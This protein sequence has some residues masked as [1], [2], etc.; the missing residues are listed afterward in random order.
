MTH[1]RTIGWRIARSLGFIPAVAVLIAL[2]L[3]TALV[4]VDVA[5]QASLADRWPRLFGAGPDGARGMLTAIASSMITV[6]GVVFSVTLVALSLASSQYSPRVL[7]TFT[8]D[9]PT[10]LVLA[11]FVGIYVYCLV[12]LRTVRGGDGTEFVPGIA[13]AGGL[14]LAV[15]GIGCLVY[16]IHHLSETVQAAAIVTRIATATLATVERVFPEELSDDAPQAPVEEAEAL[17]GEWLTLPAAQT[18][19]VIQVSIDGLL[20]VSRHNRRVVQMHAGIGDF[21]IKGQPLAAISGRTPIERDQQD[22]VAASYAIDSERTIEQDP[23]YG[24][25]QLVDIARKALSPAMNDASTAVSCVDRLTQILVTLAR[26]KDQPA[27]HREGGELRVI[28]RRPTFESLVHPVYYPLYE[29]A[30]AQHSVTMRLLWSLEQVSASTSDDERRRLL[31]REVQRLWGYVE[32]E[33]ARSPERDIAIARA[34]GLYASLSAH[35][36]EPRGATGS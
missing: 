29:D 4:E 23:A 26:R 36:P 7:R 16:F 3:A 17:S 18:G 12:V 31:A 11:V 20:A 35:S 22:R 33:H 21:I 1:L 5:S 30:R 34:A 28:A 9:R 25:Q 24:I 6:A 2:L 13:V 15:I 8:S 10:Q 19:Y 14:V 27:C 32:Q